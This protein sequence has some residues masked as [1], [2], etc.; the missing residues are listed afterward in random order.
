[1]KIQQ[2]LSVVWKKED[3]SWS[4]VVSFFQKDSINYFLGMEEES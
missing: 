2:F 1:M 3:L 4:D